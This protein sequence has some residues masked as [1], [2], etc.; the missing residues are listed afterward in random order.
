MTGH[1]C[2]ALRDD[3]SLPAFRE[4]SLELVRPEMM[5]MPFVLG[6]CDYAVAGTRGGGEAPRDAIEVIDL[7]SP[8]AF[9][10]E[11][12]GPYVQR[13]PADWRASAE[14]VEVP[15]CM[16]PAAFSER[17]E[18]LTVQRRLM[19]PALRAPGPPP[20]PTRAA[21]TTVAMLPIVGLCAVVQ[22][23][24]RPDRAT[25]LVVGRAEVQSE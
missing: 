8:E 19:R 4:H 25:P 12:S 11:N 1:Y 18:S 16:N 23:N 20:G 9:E 21:A 24:D 6:F 10:W 13:I 7:S 17:P 3:R 15:F 22:G 14:D 5:K 2:F